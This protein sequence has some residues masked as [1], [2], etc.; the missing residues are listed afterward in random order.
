M[1]KSEFDQYAEE[2]KNILKNNIKCTG[3][4]PE[5]FAEYKI[6]DTFQYTKKLN[7]EKEL[8]I[9]DFGSGIGNSI[10][11]LKKYFSSSSLISLDVSEKSL[12]I[13]KERFGNL[14]DY[15]LFDGSCIPFKDNT[16]DIIFTACVFHH[17][18]PDEHQKILSEA[19]RIL[20]PNGR[21]IIFEHN[22]YN[23]LTVHAVNTCIFDKNAILIS[24]RNFKKNLLASYFKV[25]KIAYRIFFPHALRKFRFIEKFL[26]WLP[27]GGQYYIVVRK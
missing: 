17:I 22:P 24:A 19:R 6:K 14:A 11:Y 23:P 5:Y 8:N 15:I 12:T 27:L 9:L 16:F 25:E 1:D 7:F 4:N 21:F 10:G 18:P 26:T 20:K 13:A 2:Y 3:D